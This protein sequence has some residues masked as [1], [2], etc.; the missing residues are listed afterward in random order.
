MSNIVLKICFYY[1]MKRSPVG[2]CLLC[3]ILYSLCSCLNVSWGDT[4]FS[5]CPQWP[6]PAQ[7]MGLDWLGPIVDSFLSTVTVSRAAQTSEV[8]KEIS[9]THQKHRGTASSQGAGT[10]PC[11]GR[12]WGHIATIFSMWAP[13]LKSQSLEVNSKKTR[14]LRS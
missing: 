14:N 3:I 5:V 4:C 8:V 7:K 13:M 12:H 10:P 1:L 6:A 9:G 2:T 11:A